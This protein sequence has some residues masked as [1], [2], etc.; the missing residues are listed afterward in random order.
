MC[1]FVWLCV[2]VPD[3]ASMTGWRDKLLCVLPSRF[4][5]QREAWLTLDPL[6]WVAILSVQRFNDQQPLR[7]RRAADKRLDRMT[8][9]CFDFV[10]HVLPLWALVMMKRDFQISSPVTPM[11]LQTA[12]LSKIMF[13]KL[14][15]ATFLS[16]IT[17]KKHCLCAFAS[18]NVLF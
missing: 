8:T 12:A 3:K 10:K 1:V 16:R 9:L 6:V 4:D 2:L 11:T 14:I 15:T 17:T 5:G 13:F 18:Q 7:A